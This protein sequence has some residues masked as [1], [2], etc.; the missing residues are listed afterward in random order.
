MRDYRA[1]TAQRIASNIRYFM[2]YELTDVIAGLAT[3]G[4]LILAPILM[5]LGR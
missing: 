3:V 2:R 4:I 1:S 5:A